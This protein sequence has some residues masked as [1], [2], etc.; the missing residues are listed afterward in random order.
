LKQKHK[1]H[2]PIYQ[3]NW[4][5]VKLYEPGELDGVTAC[6]LRVIEKN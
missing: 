4:K 5:K 3:T 6:N 1:R 2:Q